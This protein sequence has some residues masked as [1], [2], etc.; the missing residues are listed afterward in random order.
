MRVHHSLALAAL[1]LSGSALAQHP[2]HPAPGPVVKPVLTKAL[3]EYPGKEG[4]VLTVDYPP[5]GSSPLHHHDAYA[6][7]YVIEGSV[8][9]AVKGG[10]EVT[11]TAGQSWSEAPGDIHTVSRNASNDKPAKFVVFLLKDAGKPAVIP[12]A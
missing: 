11:L 4:L 7:V 12:G 3:P 5:G 2:A 8:V 1:L 6:F 9:M 10:K